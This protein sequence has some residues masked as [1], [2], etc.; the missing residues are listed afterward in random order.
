MAFR[1][2]CS[3]KSRQMFTAKFVVSRCAFSKQNKMGFSVPL[4]LW[5]G[6]GQCK[7]QRKAFLS[8]YLH[9]PAPNQ[10]ID[11][12]E[13]TQIPS[14]IAKH[15]ARYNNFAVKYSCSRQDVESVET[16]SLKRPGR[17]WAA[18][19]RVQ[20]WKVKFTSGSRPRSPRPY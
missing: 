16:A 5:E 19:T 14:K 6:T 10:M 9:N 1:G 15:A 12:T 4:I 11:R 2:I 18:G 7:S 3:L 17:G 13:K 8:R 20:V